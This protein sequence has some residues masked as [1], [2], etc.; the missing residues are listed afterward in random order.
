[1][2]QTKVVGMQEV[3]RDFPK[4][5]EA[6]ENELRPLFETKGALRRVSPEEI[7]QRKKKGDLDVIPSKLVCTLKPDPTNPKG[8]RKIRIVA[9]GNFVTAEGADIRIRRHRRQT[10]GRRSSQERLAGAL[11]GYQDGISQCPN[12]AG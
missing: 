10:G 1:V 3:R 12:G 2:L 9:C 6:V 5:K 7:E 4:W 11:H 8:K